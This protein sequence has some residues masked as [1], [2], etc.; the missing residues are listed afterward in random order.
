MN[1][2]SKLL[3]AVALASAAVIVALLVRRSQKPSEAFSTESAPRIAFISAVYGNYESTAKPFARQTVGADFI[4]FADNPNIDSAGHGWIVDTEPYHRTHPSPLHS[5]D[6]HNSF[7]N[8][9]HSFNVAKY[10]KQAFMNIP[11][12]QRYDAVVWI[13]G[14]IQ[15]TEPRAAEAVLARLDSGVGIVAWE[16]EWREG[17]LLSEVEA[18]VES[19]RYNSTYWNNQAQPVQDVRAQ[20]VAY[21]EDGYDE[22]LW[23]RVNPGRQNFGV[24]ITCMVAFDVRQQRV[25]SFLD[26]WYLQT[27]KHT[28]QDQVSFPFVVQKLYLLPYT[29]PDNEFAGTPHER[30]DMYIKHGHGV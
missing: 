18:S 20:Y 15:V 1:Q 22:G 27:L 10:Y 19:E 9:G 26:L 7:A 25:R 17:R 5:E 14:T 3:A 8:N 30:T 13:D 6:Q 4:M 11:R 2:R 29:L 28:T 12:L 24:W 23:K 16:H 21:L